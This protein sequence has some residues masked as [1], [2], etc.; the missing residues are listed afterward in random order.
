MLILKD[1]KKDVEQFVKK[2]KLNFKNN[3]DDAFKKTLA[4]YDEIDDNTSK[5]H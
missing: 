5:A 2:N 1:H 4:Y 3:T